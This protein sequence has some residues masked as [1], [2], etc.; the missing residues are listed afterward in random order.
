MKYI[1]PA[2]G[3]AG[4]LA[5]LLAGAAFICTLQWA[6]STNKTDKFLGGLDWDRHV[7]N[8]HIVC[9]VGFMCSFSLALIS[10]RLLPLGKP[11]NK[12]LH[13]F[14]QT[15]AL[16]CLIVGLAAGIVATSYIISS[17]SHLY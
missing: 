5:V 8:W 7:I 1:T 12:A 11:M 13:V 6:T 9:M 15:L 17:I 3:I 2:Q 14:F 4:K 16:F 10:F